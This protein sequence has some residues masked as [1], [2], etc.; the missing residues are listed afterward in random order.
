MKYDFLEEDFV[1]RLLARGNPLTSLKNVE[2]ILSQS[3]KL[4]VDIDQPELT[5]DELYQMFDSFIVL[6]AGLPVLRNTFDSSQEALALRKTNDF[7]LFQV[8]LVRNTRK[9]TEAC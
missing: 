4:E 1:Y 9:T 8:F 6:Q 2:F 3:D 5:M 7:N